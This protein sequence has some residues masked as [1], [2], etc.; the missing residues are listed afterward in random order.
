MSEFKNTIEKTINPKIKQRLKLKNTMQIPR[1]EKIV[2]N[3]GVRDAVS[4]K[5]NIERSEKVLVQIAGQKPK[6]TKAKKSISGFKVRQN[7]PIGLVVTLRGDRMYDFF[8]KLVRVVFPRFKDFRGIKKTSFD[9]RGNYT[10]G[11]PEQVVFPEIDP[12]QVER[13]QG[14]EITIVTTSNNK[15]DSIVMLEELGVPFEKDK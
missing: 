6:I 13:L 5:K 4:D 10:L 7:D 14:L 8:E 9:S 11:I 2:I 3:M 15:E 1:L 12:G